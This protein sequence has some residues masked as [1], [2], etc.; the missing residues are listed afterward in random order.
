MY[1]NALIVL[2]YF[3]PCRRPKLRH[4]GEL[5]DAFCEFDV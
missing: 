2:R 4:D 5:L 1:L 3:T